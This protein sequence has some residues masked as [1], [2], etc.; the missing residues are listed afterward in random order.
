MR[1]V[2][3]RD[4]RIVAFD[5]NR[6]R[7]A[8]NRAS[9]EVGIVDEPLVEKI[10]ER[11]KSLAEKKCLDVEQ[12]Q[13][14]VE[15]ELMKSSRKDVAK[16]YIAYRHQRNLAREAKTKD[17]LMSVIN[18]EKN[19]VTLENSNM[20]AGTISGI[21]QKIASETSRTFADNYLISEE[22][23]AAVKGNYLHI[24]DKDYLPTRSL[25]CL[26]HPIERIFENGYPAG[27]IR[28]AKHLRSAVEIMSLSLNV[29]QSEHHGGQACPAWDKVLEKYVRITYEEEFEKASNLYGFDINLTV[30]DREI[31]DYEKKDLSGIQDPFE[32]IR[33][34]SINATVDQVYSACDSFVHDLNSLRSRA[35]GQPTFSSINLGTGI[36]AEARILTRSLLQV[37]LKGVGDGE[38]ALFPIVIYKLKKGIS[39]GPG[40][41]NQDLYELACRCAARRF[42]PNFLN[43]DSSFNYDDDWREDDPQN[44]LHEVATMGCRTRVY[45]NRF[46]PKTS[47]GR[48][49]LSFS[50]INLPKLA[51]EVAIETGYLV[52][53]TPEEDSRTYIFDE[54]KNTPEHIKERVD[55]FKEKLSLMTHITAKQLDDRYHF[56][57][58]A[59]AGQFP[60]LTGAGMWNGSENLKPDDKIEAFINQG[61]LGIGFI[62]LAECLIALT[63]K[64]H[65]ESD[66]SQRIGLEI[67]TQMRDDANKYAELYQHNYSI[68]ATPAEGLSGKFTKVDRKTFGEIPGVT[69]KMY[70]TNSNHVPVG[71]ETSIR[72]KAEIE[73]PYHQLT[74]GGHIHYVELDSG[75]IN[76]PESIMDVVDIAVENNIG[77]LSVNHFQA[78]CPKC[79]HETMDE[80][81]EV[82]PKCGTKM[83]TLQRIT[84]LS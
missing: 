81:V 23:L 3:K 62:G 54:S 57:A 68:L 58:Q 47:V 46:G 17:I 35:G 59:K 41:R 19:E 77:Y 61:T 14:A 22:S 1:D 16:A 78:R 39:Y 38:T 12:I 60:M 33:Q 28:P 84:G 66:E 2:K 5:E 44:Y 15:M 67:I 27:S 79:N 64:H 42:F 32:R 70:Y 49:N 20:D 80:G 24:H 74:L 31:V 30:R 9:A 65:G 55:L 13:D 11:V 69:D 34:H 25:T 7:E 18:A 73:G 43:L 45:E 50:T 29:L 53:Q 40:A 75:P 72:H 21:L 8:I 76:N 37:I 36:S 26:Q 10:V 82:C 63:G 71:Y 52:D 83:G 48:G 6:I 51:I 4:G 56:Q